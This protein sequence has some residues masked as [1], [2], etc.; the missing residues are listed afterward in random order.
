[1]TKIMKYLFICCTHYY[2]LSTIFLKKKMHRKKA[3]QHFTNI[4]CTF[5]SKH[6]GHCL[7]DGVCYNTNDADSTNPCSVCDPLLSTSEWSTNISKFYMF[8]TASFI[9]TMSHIIVMAKQ[10]HLLFL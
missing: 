3:K 9:V 4:K 1:M 8:Y 7:I 5:Y 10:T 6:I 2:G